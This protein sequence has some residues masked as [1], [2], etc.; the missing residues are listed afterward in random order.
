[1]PGVRQTSH[2]YDRLSVLMIW[3]NVGECL[4]RPGKSGQRLQ[5]GQA[6]GHEN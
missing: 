4:M 5:A 6:D 2:K 1:M 3:H